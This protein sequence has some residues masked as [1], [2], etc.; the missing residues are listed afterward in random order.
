MNQVANSELRN[1]FYFSKARERG[2]THCSTCTCPQNQQTC[3]SGVERGKRKAGGGFRHSCFCSWLRSGQWQKEI[4]FSHTCFFALEIV[5][6]PKIENVF[7]QYKNNTIWCFAVQNWSR[8]NKDLT[9]YHCTLG[10][11]EQEKSLGAWQ[12]CLLLGGQKQQMRLS[13]LIRTPG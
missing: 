11:Q 3:V 6:I 12:S 8:Q 7:P 2:R 1:T 9:A 10:L 13:I 5:F 4:L